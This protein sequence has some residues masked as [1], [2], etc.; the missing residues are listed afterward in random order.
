[1]TQPEPEEVPLDEID[2][3]NMPLRHAVLP[4]DLLTRIKQLW[5]VLGPYTPHCESPKT[6]EFYSS[7][8]QLDSEGP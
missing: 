6:G 7:E 4:P 1:M 3:R 5:D 2:V 8:L